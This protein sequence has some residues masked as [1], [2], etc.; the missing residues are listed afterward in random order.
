MNVVLVKD[1][2]VIFK[3]KE[4][5]I[6]RMLSEDYTVT[7]IASELNENR[8]GLE[9]VMARIR[10]KTNCSTIGGVVAYFFRNGL[11]E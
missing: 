9:G 10:S 4:V 1:G 3:E 7:A 2:T 8:R 11:I 6:V 5:E